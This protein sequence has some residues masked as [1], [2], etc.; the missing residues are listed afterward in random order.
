MQHR[1]RRDSRRWLFARVEGAPGP[2]G[3]EVDRDGYY[4][5]AING[6]G[7]VPRF[8]SD[9]RIEREVRSQPW[10]TSGCH[11]VET[12]STALLI[13]AVVSGAAFVTCWHC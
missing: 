12:C 11:V 6:Q 7:R 13:L 9:G 4:W 2:D 3:A 5:S 10:I 8:D 1:Y